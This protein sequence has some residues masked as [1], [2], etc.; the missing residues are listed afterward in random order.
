MGSIRF[1]FQ[2]I[3]STAHRRPFVRG[4]LLDVALVL[5]V[6]IVAIVGFGLGIVAEAIAQLGGDLGDALGLTRP[7]IGSVK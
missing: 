6:G 1:A 2:T 7:E 4:K 3:W 5:G